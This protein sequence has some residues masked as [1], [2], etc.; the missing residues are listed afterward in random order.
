CMAT[1]LELPT[2]V[3]MP[4][5]GLGTWQALQGAARDA[6]MFAIDVGSRHFD[7][8]TEEVVV[9]REDLF[10]VSKL[11]STFQERSLVRDARQK[12][13]AA[14][15]L[16]CLDLYLMHWPTGFKDFNSRELSVGVL[17]LFPLGPDMPLPLSNEEC[18]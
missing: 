16:D 11:W 2:R 12:T 6:V 13:L 5:L 8:K 3:R 7:C 10:I 1:Y 9:R 15:R 4:T 18:C 14:L 17:P